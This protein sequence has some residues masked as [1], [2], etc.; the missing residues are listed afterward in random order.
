[1]RYIRYIKTEVIAS[2]KQ[3]QGLLMIILTPFF[4]TLFLAFSMRGIYH[5]ILKT[6]IRESMEIKLF[7]SFNSYLKKSKFY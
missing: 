5:Y 4:L 7:N 3:F 1:M 2:F 6:M